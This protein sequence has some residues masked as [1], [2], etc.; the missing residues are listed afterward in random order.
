[1]VQVVERLPSKHKALSSNPSIAKE[2]KR[3][4]FRLETGVLLSVVEFPRFDKNSNFGIIYDTVRGSILIL[5]AIVCKIN[6][7]RTQNVLEKMP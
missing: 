3:K 7:L 4:K 6:M 1:V 2:K 5:L